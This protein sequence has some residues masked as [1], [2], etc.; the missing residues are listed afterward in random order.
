M[1]YEPVFGQMPLASP[2]E[3]GHGASSLAAASA[4]PMFGAVASPAPVQHFAPA[5]PPSFLQRALARLF[6]VPEAMGGL[7]SNEDLHSARRQGLLAL[8]ASML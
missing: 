5:K 8:G 7:L 6:P 3:L 4:P 1:A 2:F